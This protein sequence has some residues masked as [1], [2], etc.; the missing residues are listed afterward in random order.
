MLSDYL[1]GVIL[2]MIERGRLLNANVPRD[3]LGDYDALRV[4]C[5]QQIDESIRQLERLQL[6]IKSFVG[7]E[8][9]RIFKRIVSE[10]DALET[11]GVASL[12]RAS[13][14]DHKINSLI[15]RITKEIEYPLLTP[16]IT[17]LSQSYFC[18]YPAFNLLCIPLVE[19]NFLLHLPDLY[20]ELAHPFF[21]EKNDP[22]V[23][24]FQHRFED[25]VV[26]ILSYFEEEKNKAEYRRGPKYLYELLHVWQRSWIQF[27]IEEF[28]CDLY[29]VYTLGPAFAWS[30]L[31]L[32]IKRG[33]DP[34]ETSMRITSHPCDHARMTAMLYA[35]NLSGFE[36]TAQKIQQQWNNLLEEIGAEEKP[37]YH[38]C[39]PTCLIEKVVDH[40]W[41]AVK[42]I[43]ARIATPETQDPIH[44][45]LNQAWEQFWQN[46]LMYVEWEKRAIEKLLAD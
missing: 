34:Y 1:A 6:S 32:V 28:F 30:H 35:L 38:R 2:Q 27:W 43:K 3:L 24:P 42:D 17:T 41:Y 5:K 7:S 33:G 21:A 20:H 37:E 31:H 39:Y 19:G 25:G 12:N 23:E 22:V 26:D 40:A 29:G 13:D 18:I 11:V 46:P 15:R 45:L 14:K 16:V 36:D 44:S 10:M 8:Q 9:L 4:T